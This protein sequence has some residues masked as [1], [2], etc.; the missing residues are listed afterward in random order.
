MN[1]IT[2]YI[3]LELLI[4]DKKN[5]RTARHDREIIIVY[6]S[7]GFRNSRFEVR[8]SMFEKWLRTCSPNHLLCFTLSRTVTIFAPC[9]DDDDGSPM[10]MMPTTKKKQHQ[11]KPNANIRRRGWLSPTQI[12]SHALVQATSIVSRPPAPEVIGT[13]CARVAAPDRHHPH[14]PTTSTRAVNAKT[15]SCAR[16]VISI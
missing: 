14:P 11:P 7:D 16:K 1:N 6:Q 9:T 5:K 8:N 12:F 15:R 4:N 3:T 10:T 13:Y 2:T